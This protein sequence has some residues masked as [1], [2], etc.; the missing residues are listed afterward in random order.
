[1]R[2][3]L[4]ETSDT[5]FTFVTITIDDC[6]KSKEDEPTIIVTTPPHKSIATPPLQVQKPIVPFLNW[7][8]GKKDQTHIDKIKETFS[9]DKINIFLLEAI[10]QMSSYVELRGQLLCPRELS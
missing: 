4:N 6:E 3:K 10:Q 1:M 7:L 2:D 5:P 8:R 9:Q